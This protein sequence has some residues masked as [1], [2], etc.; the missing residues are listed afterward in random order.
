[1]YANRGAQ[2]L[3]HLSKA[4]LLVNDGQIEP[5]PRPGKH[6]IPHHVTYLCE[7]KYC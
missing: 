7:C 5:R 4:T 2:R 6:K 1:M 3:G